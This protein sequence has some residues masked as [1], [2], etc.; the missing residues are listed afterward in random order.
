MNE[1]EVTK[2]LSKIVVDILNGTIDD[3]AHWYETEGHRL[4]KDEVVNHISSIG[5]GLRDETDKT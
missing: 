2:K 4:T 1:D 3:L 5:W